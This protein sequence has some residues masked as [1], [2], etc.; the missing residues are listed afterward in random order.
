MIKVSEGY[1]GELMN[2]VQ[3]VVDDTKDKVVS[4]ELGNQWGKWTAEEWN[5]V[6]GEDDDEIKELTDLF[7]KFIGYKVNYKQDGSHKH[8]GQMVEYTFKFESPSGVKSEFYTDMCLM[9]GWNHHED[10]EIG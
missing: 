10:C 5:L 4:E 3:Y 6:E 2:L 1:T 7:K 9:M 8:D